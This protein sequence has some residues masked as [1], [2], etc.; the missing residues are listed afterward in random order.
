MMSLK[1]LQWAIPVS[2]LACLLSACALPKSGVRP[3]AS[4][5]A[6]GVPVESRAVSDATQTTEAFPSASPAEPVI[7]VNCRASLSKDDELVKA[8][9]EQRMRD[10]NFYA[11]LAQVQSLPSEVPVVAALRADILRQ[12]QMPQAENW[13]QA[14]QGGCMAG[15]AEHG[16][17]L[18]AAQRNEYSIALKRLISA[19]RLLPADSRVRNDLGY[20]YLLLNMDAPAEFELRT[21]YEL[22]PEDKIPGFNLAVLSLLRRDQAAWEFWSERLA[23][24]TADRDELLRSCQYLMRQRNR[25]QSSVSCPMSP[26]LSGA[27]SIQR[28]SKSSQGE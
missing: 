19:S 3:I 14:L 21:A 1:A 11:A 25:S 15:R 7:R 16:L 9:V 18:L 8:V 23:F 20:L 13:Y 17:G 26:R 6:L 4:E 24:S 28:P 2:A 10:G 22:A 12:L 5:A 27:S